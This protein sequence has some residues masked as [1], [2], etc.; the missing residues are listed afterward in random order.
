[1]FKPI[2]PLLRILHTL[3][4]I[5]QIGSLGYLRDFNTKIKND[6]KKINF[7]KLFKKKI[8]LGILNEYFGICL[9]NE[10]MQCRVP[11][12]SSGVIEILCSPYINI[13]HLV[14]LVESKGEDKSIH[15]CTIAFAEVDW[16]MT[17]QHPTTVEDPLQICIEFTPQP[18]LSLKMSTKQLGFEFRVVVL[19]D[20]LPSKAQKFVSPAI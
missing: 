16:K 18:S 13:F 11:Q 17:V 5:L 7:I 9:S 20:R 3:I 1:M 12:A 4:L 19:I 14:L 6:T 2:N 10:T 8:L 15:F